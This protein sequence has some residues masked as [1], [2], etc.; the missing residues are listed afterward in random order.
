MATLGVV[1]RSL[2]L[3]DTAYSV[4]GVL[5]PGFNLPY[6]AEVWVPMP[7]SQDGLPLA[8]RAATAHELVARL[9]PGVSLREADTELK[10]LARRLEQAH[11]EIRRGWSYGLVPLRHQLL[12]DLEGR[13]QRLLGALGVAVGFL[14]L[15]CCANVASLLLARGVS[16]EG[17]MAIRLSLGAAR[18]RLV[19]QLLT[20]SLVLA[21]FG[22]VLGVLL[23]TWIQPLLGALNPIQ[24]TGLGAYLG[25]FR[26]DGRV[27][28]FSVAVTLLTGI[29]FGLVPAVTVGRSPSPMGVTSEGV[30]RTR[31]GRRR[32]SPRCPRNRRGRGG[33]H[34]PGRRRTGRAVVPAICSGPSSGTTPTGS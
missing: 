8:Q 1:G 3:D 25:D 11:P 33:R 23:A 26:I 24:A 7:A 19:R 17:E 30:A 13:A 34:S 32:S 31:R 12:G 15:I 28:L 2:T 14:L 5:P 18:G 10:G 22:G 4:V 6:S 9:K 20:E 29:A 21:L 16:R 27:L